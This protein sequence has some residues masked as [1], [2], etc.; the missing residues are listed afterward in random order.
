MAIFPVLGKL[1]HMKCVNTDRKRIEGCA[2]KVFR[3]PWCQHEKRLTRKP[4]RKKTDTQM[5]ALVATTFNSMTH[6][7]QNQQLQTQEQ[8][9]CQQVWGHRWRR[10]GWIVARQ[11]LWGI[12]SAQEGRDM[13][14]PSDSWQDPEM[15][16]WQMLRRPQRTAQCRCFPGSC[17]WSPFLLD[18]SPMPWPSDRTLS[19]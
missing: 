14:P 3:I 17:R 7:G 9:P 15:R 6:K 4:G 2:R 13:G 10:W 12:S 18:L 5:D 16:L 1:T 8:D 19:K 11:I